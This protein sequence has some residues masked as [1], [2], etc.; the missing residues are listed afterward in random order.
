[1]E[2]NT[3]ETL[4]TSYIDQDL[5]GQEIENP[6]F[7]FKAKWYDLQKPK[8]INEFL[9]DTSAIANTFGLDGFIIIGYDSKLKSFNQV[10]FSDCNLK[11]SSHLNDLINKRVD[12]LFDIA[13]YD[14]LVNNNKISVM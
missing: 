6:K 10:S 2:R 12:R 9:K 13:V 14:L 8:D 5:G 1:M 3:I 11:D 4:V 7:D